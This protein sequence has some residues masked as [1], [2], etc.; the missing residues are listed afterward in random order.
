MTERNKEIVARWFDEY[1][2]KGNPAI[3]DE[4]GADD[5]V[6]SYPLTGELSG[7]EAVKTC[8]EELFG[9]FE[10]M[11]FKTTEPLIAEGD[12]VVGRWIGEGTHTG[13]FAGIPATGKKVSFTGTTI[14]TVADGKIVHELGE[15]DAWLVLRQLGVIPE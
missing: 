5:L 12:K 1:W 6:F 9:A 11:R 4:L 8:N 14:Y 13:E 7:R 10:G 15:E 3:V 2:G